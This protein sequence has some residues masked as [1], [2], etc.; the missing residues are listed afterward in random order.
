[1][2]ITRWLSSLSDPIAFRNILHVLNEK[3]GGMNLA[4][5]PLHE[6]HG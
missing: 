4:F 5:C 6:E 2:T 3:S 1:M